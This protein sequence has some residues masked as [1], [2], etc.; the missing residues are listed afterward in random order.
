MSL[1]AGPLV[2]IVRQTETANLAWY[3]AE[4][5]V[6]QGRGGGTGKSECVI[7]GS[8]N[9]PHGDGSASIGPSC[10]VEKCFAG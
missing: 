3:V 4:S 9:T 2:S 8:R 6:A 1:V 5:R 7:N 10:I